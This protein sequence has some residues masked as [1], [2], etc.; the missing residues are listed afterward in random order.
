MQEAR[1]WGVWTAYLN[2]A[3]DFK[4]AMRDLQLG[5]T[6]HAS[7]IE[8]AQKAQDAWAEFEGVFRQDN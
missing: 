3:E 4:E 2:A 6:S 5:L 7:A 8:L 1:Y